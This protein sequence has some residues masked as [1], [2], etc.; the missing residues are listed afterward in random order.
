MDENTVRRSGRSRI[1]GVLGLAQAIAGQP[2]LQPLEIA[3]FQGT[4]AVQCPCG[5]RKAILIPFIVGLP[6]LAE[7]K[8]CGRAFRITRFEYDAAKPPNEQFSIRVTGQDPVIARPRD[9]R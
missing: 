9:G 1:V 7:C 4:A 5:V 6:T 2:P 3:G 8:E